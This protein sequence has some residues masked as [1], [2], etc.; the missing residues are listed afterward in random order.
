MD[1]EIRRATP[2]DAEAIAMVHVESW[3]TTYADLLPAEF[4]ASLDVAKRAASWREHLLRGNMTGFVV[5]DSSGIFGFITGGKLREAIESYDAELYAIY[6]LEQKQNRGAGRSLTFGL[7]SALRMQGFTSVVVWVLEK[8]LP[9][10]GFYQ[11][12][13]GVRLAEKPIEIGGRELTELAFGWPNLA[14]C[15]R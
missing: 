12:L 14:T 7:A 11:R 4:L 9:A 6:L 2:H 3:R 13:G 10:V 5:E 1:Y 15:L 8:N